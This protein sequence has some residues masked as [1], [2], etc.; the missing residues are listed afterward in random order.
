MTT[1]I[2]LMS[3]TLLV[4]CTCIGCRGAVWAKKGPVTAHHFAHVP[5]SIEHIVELVAV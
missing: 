3:K 1:V 4:N 5:N 2:S